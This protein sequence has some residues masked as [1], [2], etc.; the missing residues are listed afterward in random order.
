MIAGTISASTYLSIFAI[1]I[2]P[3]T[4]Q[5][6]LASRMQCGLHGVLLGF[7]FWSRRAIRNC[8]DFPGSGTKLNPN[9]QLTWRSNLPWG[10]DMRSVFGLSVS[11][12]VLLLCLSQFLPAQTITGTISGDVTD[13]SGAVVAGATVTVENLGTSQKRTAT[14]TA[15]GTFVVPD[16]AI[17]KYRVTATAE[18]FKTITQ[19]AEVLTGAVTRT[20]FC[21]LYTSDAADE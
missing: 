18:G 10:H 6:L 9:S 11:L 8:I 16:L 14:T 1:A 7:D 21:L 13:T 2:L 15:G 5:S 12:A 4:R 19:I 3:A 17:G 20:G